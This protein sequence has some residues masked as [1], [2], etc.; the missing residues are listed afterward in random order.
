MLSKISKNDKVTQREL[1][2]DLGLSV[3]T[4]NLLMKKMIKE[5]L[6]KMNQVSS[7]QVLYMLTPMGIGNKALKTVSYL[8]GHYQAINE[9]K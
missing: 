5:G 3:S 9:N 1:P 2:K 8:K 7:K 4:V 6:I